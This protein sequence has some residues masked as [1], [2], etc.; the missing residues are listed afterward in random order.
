MPKFNPIPARTGMISDRTRSESL[1]S[2]VII[3]CSRYW[4]LS[5]DIGTAKAA[6]IKNTIGTRFEISA[7]F[8]EYFGF[9]ISPFPSLFS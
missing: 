2:R 3:S 9:F 7:P 4:M 6:N 1:A 5:P 8:K